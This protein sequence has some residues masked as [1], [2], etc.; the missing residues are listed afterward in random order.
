MENKHGEGKCS[1]EKQGSRS[2]A[3]G[4]KSSPD[5]EYLDPLVEEFV[6]FTTSNNYVA[7]VKQFYSDNC[8]GFEDYEN[9]VK[10]GAGMKL[11]WMETY[12]KYMELVDEQLNG[13]CRQNGYSAMDVFNRI[14]DTISN[15]KYS[16]FAP[17]FLKSIEETFFF[18]QMSAYAL[19]N[20]KER[21]AERANRQCDNE[22]I[23]GVWYLDPDRVDSDELRDWV[24]NAG[25]V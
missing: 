12:R 8:N 25:E 9:F 24:E 13:Y 17:L 1:E 10:S 18:E 2:P 3:K 19:Q 16:D 14:Q 21:D 15:D 11:E 7:T 4:E 23:N 5:E 20:D 6:E 22:S